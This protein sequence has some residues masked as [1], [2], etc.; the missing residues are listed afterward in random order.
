MV[1]IFIWTFWAGLVIG[2]GVGFG[3]W[4]LGLGLA[5]E[6]SRPYAETVSSFI[7]LVWLGRGG[8][9]G[10]IYFLARRRTEYRNS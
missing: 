5:A 3:F 8:V 4:V 10:V 6:V 9:V 2:F 7:R 1:L